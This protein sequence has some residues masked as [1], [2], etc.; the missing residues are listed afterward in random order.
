MHTH[1]IESIDFRKP[2]ELS[3]RL[4]D[5]SNQAIQKASLFK[6]E[7]DNNINVVLKKFEVWFISSFDKE[8]RTIIKNTTNLN[9]T[10][11]NYTCNE[12][13]SHFFAISMKD[14]NENLDFAKGA[15]MSSGHLSYRQADLKQ[16]L[17][18]MLINKQKGTIQIKKDSPFNNI[19]YELYFDLTA[20]YFSEDL[21]LGTK[22]YTAEEITTIIEHEIGHPVTLLEHASDFLFKTHIISETMRG[23]NKNDPIEQ[24]GATENIINKYIK[25][26][27]ESGKISKKI[28]GFLGRLAAN[29]FEIVNKV[30]KR[31]INVL[32]LPLKILM[33]VLVFGFTFLIF[34]I[35]IALL[36]IGSYFIKSVNALLDIYYLQTNLK[37][38]DETLSRRK[39]YFHERLADEFVSRHGMGSYLGSTLIKL[40]R[41]INMYTAQQTTGNMNASKLTFFGKVYVRTVKAIYSTFGLTSDTFAFGYEETLERVGRL[42]QNNMVIF[43]DRNLAPDISRHYLKDTESLMKSIKDIQKGFVKD[44]FDKTRETILTILHPG[45][46]LTAATTGHLPNDYEKMFS[47]VENLINNKLFYQAAKIQ[48]YL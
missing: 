33:K 1:G 17:D 37:S 48:S 5:I 36:F 3:K 11:I 42:I 6:K 45:T 28:T 8:L 24:I 39:D 19:E 23:I 14:T 43:K 10:R 38:A 31:K 44:K 21:I 47:E 2:S 9:L 13:A 15:A 22:N 41:N 26:I 46:W 30:T 29:I 7:Y 25:I 27:K 20:A 16:I 35:T 32:F 40:N 12:Y 34:S 18:E 4:I